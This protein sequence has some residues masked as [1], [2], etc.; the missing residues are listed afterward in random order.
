MLIL[1]IDTAH[2]NGS[3]TLAQADNSTFKVL[4]TLPVDGGAFSAQLVPRIAQA[5][6]ENQLRKTDM[7]AYVACIGPGSFTGLRIGLAGVKG[8][9]EVLP[10][11]IAAVSSL[12]A[13]AA[14]APG[15]AENLLA[16]LDAGR[17][18]FYAGE[19]RRSGH[20]LTRVSESLCTPDELTMLLQRGS[21]VIASQP[22]IAEFV[23]SAGAEVTTVPEVDSAQIAEVGWRKLLEG[24]T[25]SPDALDANYLRRDDSLFSK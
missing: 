16:V 11:P 24:E 12:E 4:Q 25:I 9:A 7:D 8:L 14:S 23:R 3:I 6:K 2:K 5:L 10:R 22:H 13:L 15:S 20:A 1:A 19:Y 21:A 17:S 18:E